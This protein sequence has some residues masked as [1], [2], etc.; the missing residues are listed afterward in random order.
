[1]FVCAGVALHSGALTIFPQ[2]ASG[3]Q[4]REDGMHGDGWP[5]KGTAPTTTH[6]HISQVQR[7]EDGIGQHSD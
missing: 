6:S 1:M 4:Y 3:K 5:Q 2:Q 7:N